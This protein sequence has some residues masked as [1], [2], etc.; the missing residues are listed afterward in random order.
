[1]KYAVAQRHTM[2]R[3]RFETSRT[4]AIPSGSPQHT[5]DAPVRLSMTG[6]AG[7]GQGDRPDDHSM[8]TPLE[9]AFAPFKSLARL[10][11]Q[12]VA[13]GGEFLQMRL[14]PERCRVEAAAG[15]EPAGVALVD[16]GFALGADR[17]DVRI[18]SATYSV[19]G[20]WNLE[21]LRADLSAALTARSLVPGEP[22]VLA[23]AIAGHR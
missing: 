21:R 11:R 1:M 16:V 22:C 14:D 6:P 8:W 13:V 3:D 4:H 20:T 17:Y 5:R 10:N 7:P 12:T 18:S 23:E 19:D 15:S 9:R 2:A